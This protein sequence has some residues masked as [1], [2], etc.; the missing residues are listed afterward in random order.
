MQSSDRNREPVRLTTEIH[1]ARE[2]RCGTRGTCPTVAKSVPVAE[3]PASDAGRLV[4]VAPTAREVA[5]R[6][7]DAPGEDKAGRGGAAGDQRELRLQP[8]GEVRRLPELTAKMLDGAGELL[9]LGLDVV[10]N[11]LLGAGRSGHQRFNAACV[12][13]ASRI[14]CCGTGGVPFLM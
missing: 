4:S 14:A 12:S 6:R 8:A 13:F 9:A 10:P 5:H 3:R 1:S 7:A 11:L 2:S